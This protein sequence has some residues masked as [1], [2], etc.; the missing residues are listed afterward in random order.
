MVN[1][2]TERNLLSAPSTFLIAVCYSLI[3]MSM[4]LP[5][6]Y[7]SVLVVSMALM[8]ACLFLLLPSFIACSRAFSDRNFLLFC[9]VMII[10]PLEGIFA[11]MRHDPMPALILA[12]QLFAALSTIG[13]YVVIK[14]GDKEVFLRGFVWPLGV[15]GALC[16]FA[17]FVVSIT[18]LDNQNFYAA[19]LLP[20]L[21]YLALIKKDK[22]RTVL[23]GGLILWLSIYFDSRLTLAAATF[24]LVFA[25]L[26]TFNNF[27]KTFVFL[28]FFLIVGTV[29]LAFE[30]NSVLNAV[31]TNRVLIWSYYMSES[32]LDML[33]GHGYIDKQIADDTARYVEVIIERGA[34]AAYGTQSMVIRYLYEN[35][36]PLTFVS[37]AYFSSVLLRK[38]KYWAVGFLGFIAPLLESVKFGV[39]SVYGCILVV[40]FLTAA[41]E[42]SQKR[43]SRTHLQ[44]KP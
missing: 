28:L 41:T 12:T 38:N 19:L 40:F 7:R 29:Y 43:E 21:T 30:Y 13:L 9:L 16:V 8:G 39:P 23:V 27:Q 22:P 35:G 11:A 14:L 44:V 3:C 4:A 42:D 26:P 18:I 24:C 33:I 1:L 2:S 10:T 32:G 34:N 20:L 36:I 37:Y 5:V 6:E 25:F 15:F 31:L 17:F